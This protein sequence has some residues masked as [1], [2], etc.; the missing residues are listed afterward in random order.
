MTTDTLKEGKKTIEWWLAI[1]SILLYA[2][3]SIAYGFM[4]DGTWDDDCVVRYYNVKNA[5]LEPRQFVSIWNRPLFVIIF[6][7]PVHLGKYSILFGMVFISSI[8]SWAL[9]KSAVIMKLKNAWM[10]V[11]FFAFQV[12][13]FGVSRNAL[14]EPLSVA[15][16][17][18]GLLFYLRKQWLWFVVVGSLMPLARLELSVLLIFWVIPLLKE[19]KW[20]YI[21]A[22]GIPTLFINFAGTAIDGD[23]LY[24]Y[25]KTFGADNESNRY[26]H[27]TFGHYFQR[28]IYV[29]GPIIF[30]YFVLGLLNRFVKKKLDKF[31]VGQFVTGFML[32][33][34]FSWLLNMGNAAGFLRNLVPLTPLAAM[35]AL[36]GYNWW[37]DGIG[38]KTIAVK[39]ETEHDKVEEPREVKADD[40]NL[41]ARQRRHMSNQ[42][43]KNAELEKRMAEQGKVETKKESK[44]GTGKY[45]LLLYT[46]IVVLLTYTLFS[47]VLQGH[48]KLMDGAKEGEEALYQLANLYVMLGLAALLVILVAM[49]WKK[50]ISAKMSVA[51]GLVVM[52]GSGA[53]TFITEPPDNHMN[54]ERETLG[55]VSDLYVDSYLED[56]PLYC[57]HSWF[58]WANDLPFYPENYKTER[59]VNMENLANAPDSSI[60]I[61]ENHYSHR[62][63]GDVQAAFFENNKQYVLL[64]RTISSDN[65]IVVNMFQKVGADSMNPIAYHDKFIEHFPDEPSGYYSRGTTKMGAGDWEGGLADLSIAVEKDPE[66]VD[67]FFNRGLAYFNQQQYYEAIADFQQCAKLKPENPQYFY[68]TGAAYASMNSVDSALIYYVEAIKLKDDYWEAYANIGN[69]YYQK[70][71]WVNASEFYTRALQYKPDLVQASGNRAQCLVNMQDWPNAIGEFN[72]LNS[73]QPG[74]ASHIYN[75]GYAY[76]QNG[77][78]QQACGFF[79]QAL[80]LGHPNAAAAVA[81]VCN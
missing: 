63:S 25:H 47:Y 17:A 54:P 8:S 9:Y 71:D 43:R 44:G 70:Q 34:V 78:N 22:L 48:H 68:N 80:Q 76:S 61:W 39:P 20:K 13:F 66:Y 7:L 26:G 41:T 77:N 45:W 21:I 64:Y 29:L 5:F 79:Q 69:I 57:N 73:L 49:H 35:L 33:V 10:V 46:G 60:I 4:A 75:L 62:L 14:T 31:I 18:L 74:N 32:Y 58:F 24:L 2:G 30:Y 51:I 3:V 36:Y 38:N 81:S 19:K 12:F 55:M 53:F 23:P 6:C 11:P 37:L 65:R 50:A 42:Q 1:L 40:A 15:I 27:T 56:L 28:Y 67:A 59:I 52:L 72:R 16:L